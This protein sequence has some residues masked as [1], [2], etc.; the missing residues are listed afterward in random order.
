MAKK[1]ANNVVINDQELMPTSIGVYSNKSK[2]PIIIF[3]IIIVFAS[4]A[5]FL[6]DIQ[7]G[8]SK[9]LGKEETINN[10]G[11]GNEPDNPDNPDNPDKPV[12]D[13]AKYSLS[14]TDNITIGDVVISDLQKNNENLS[15]TI[16]TTKQMNLDSYYLEFYDDNN[17][18]LGRSKVSDNTISESSP[19]KLYY[20][21]PPTSSKFTFVKRGESDY[22]PVSINYDDKKE[23][24]LTCK[25]SN[26]E[27]YIYTFVSDEL[28]K[29][30]YSYS[31][32]NTSENYA[33][34]FNKY[35]NSDSY[36]KTL[37]NVTSSLLSFEN[38]FEYSLKIDL[39]GI[40]ND[41]LKE[42][43]LSGLY[44]VKTSPKE[45]KFKME[46]KNYICNI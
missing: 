32:S 18:F 14:S 9:L 8:I 11:G 38:G 13:D 40:S 26:N 19:V 15:I 37:D 39:N 44:K 22:P 42:I 45:V 7:K 3:F 28:S 5:F 10:K 20:I 1:K 25:N 12:E 16:T 27:E 21:I 2:N 4:I 29:V 34:M 33:N 23:G 43:D 31:L 36:Y 35:S 46:A 30:V 24:I 17:M 6:P 41:T